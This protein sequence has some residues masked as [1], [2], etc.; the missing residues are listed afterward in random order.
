MSEGQDPEQASGRAWYIVFLCM[1]AYVF[2]FIDRQVLALLIEPI[3]VS[4]T[5]LRAHETVLDLVCRLLLEK[6]KHKHSDQ[7]S[8]LPA[9]TQDCCTRRTDSIT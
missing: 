6:Q 4:Y 9:I 5:H 3:P 7:H 8:R 2:S 1:V